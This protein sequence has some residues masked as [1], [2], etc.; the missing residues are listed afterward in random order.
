MSGSW[1]GRN[2][3]GGSPGPGFP[4]Y[5]SETEARAAGER[6]LKRYP[7]AGYGSRYKVRPAANG[8]GWELVTERA[9]SCD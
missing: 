3:W 8:F 1:G 6:F 9:S 7:P 4:V 5:P 2:P